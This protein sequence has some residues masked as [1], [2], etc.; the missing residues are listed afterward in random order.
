MKIAPCQRRMKRVMSG[1]ITAP[2]IT[3]PTTADIASPKDN[4][5]ASAPDR[6]SPRGSMP[7]DVLIS[8]TVTT[9]ITGTSSIDS[10]LIAR[11]P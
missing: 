4:S 11:K 7:S 8:N 3:P 1:R 9:I 2:T 5:P 10:R 6:I